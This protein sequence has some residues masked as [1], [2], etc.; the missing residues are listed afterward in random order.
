MKYKQLKKGRSGGTLIEV[1]LTIT[2]FSDFDNLLSVFF[3]KAIFVIVLIFVSSQRTMKRV[4]DE[5]ITS[6]RPA[7]AAG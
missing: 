2:I 5:A 6:R 3:D 1:L 7:V 4:P